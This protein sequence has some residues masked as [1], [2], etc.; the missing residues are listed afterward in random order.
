MSAY[1]FTKTWA[2]AARTPAFVIHSS[3]TTGIPKPLRYTPELL[4][5]SHTQRYLP[6]GSIENPELVTQ[7]VL[8]T[9]AM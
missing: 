9:R 4:A 3:G 8:G 2:E 1:P 5:I 7:P 6:D